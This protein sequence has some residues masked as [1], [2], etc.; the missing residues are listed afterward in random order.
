M[1][2]YP[3]GSVRVL[4]RYYALNPRGNALIAPVFT[5]RI[6]ETTR[7]IAFFARLQRVNRREG[8]LRVNECVVTGLRVTRR[9]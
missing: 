1:Y 5:R 6:A 2:M 8:R 7:D 3:G 4:T 9:C